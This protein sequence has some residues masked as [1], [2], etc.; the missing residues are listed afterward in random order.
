MDTVTDI[1][2][3]QMTLLTAPT[4]LHPQCQGGK[5]DMR[6]SPKSGGPPLLE[7]QGRD[8]LV[9]RQLRVGMGVLGELQCS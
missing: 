3:Q 8:R 4:S 1:L 6:G 5:H 7:G 9:W 2:V